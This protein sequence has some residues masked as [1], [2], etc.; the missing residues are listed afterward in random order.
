MEKHIAMW[1]CPRSRSTMLCRS[2]E[3]RDDCLI[4]N[5]PFYPPYLMSHGL[6]HPGR[7]E[8]ISKQETDY[9]QVIKMI[10]ADLPEGITFS[11]QKH[12]AKNVLPEYGRDWL[13]CAKHFFLIRTPKEIIASYYKINNKVDFHDT[14][15]LELQNIFHEIQSVSNE[16]PIVIDA[17]KFIEN[18][19]QNLRLLCS[20][21]D[22]E[23]S[24]KMLRWEAGL[25]NSKIL[26]GLKDDLP[27]P[28][29]AWHSSLANSTGF[30]PY[31][32]NNCDLPGEFKS[33]EQKCNLIYDELYEYCLN[34]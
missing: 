9:R 12:I 13:K 2:F 5:E 20:K 4:F 18:P 21:L 1:S 31:K 16:Y 6:D 8:I 10:T 27:I 28:A 15:F 26:P 7:E 22:I 23:F 29:Q 33:L 25:E 24:D 17:N 34:K 3:Q 19:E 11:F 30:K 32:A 14:G